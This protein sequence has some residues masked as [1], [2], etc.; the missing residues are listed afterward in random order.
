MEHPTRSKGDET[1]MH[2]RWHLS[3]SPLYPIILNDLVSL[4]EVEGLGN[5]SL[6][7]FL[8]TAISTSTS[9][10]AT[11]GEA[12]VSAKNYETEQPIKV[13]IPSNANSRYNSFITKCTTIAGMAKKDPEVYRMVMPQIE[14]MYTNCLLMQNCK[15]SKAKAAQKTVGKAGEK[16]PIVP[17]ALRKDHSDEVNLA[18]YASKKKKKKKKKT[19]GKSNTNK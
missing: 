17:D 9:S 2:S 4:M 10:A 14:T 16:V 8:T 5:A 11:S 3:N 13:K 6:P 15:S 7:A 1:T 12:E 18:N 19:K